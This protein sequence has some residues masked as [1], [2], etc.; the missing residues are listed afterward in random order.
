[1]DSF[2]DKKYQTPTWLNKKLS[3]RSMLKSAA[4]ATAI[5]AAPAFAL[6]K[7]NN[8]LA[9]QSALN[10][11]KWQ[12]LNAVFDHLFPASDSGPSAKDIQAT[13]YLYQLV[14]EQPTSQDEID[15]IYRGIGWLNGYTQS[16]QQLNFINLNTEQKEQTL[17]A[18]SRSEAGQNW[19]NMM[20]LN[21][22]EAMLSPPAYG[23]NPD[24]VGWKW[25][26][27][28]AGFPLPK[29]GNRYFE[30]PPRSQVNKKS[31]QVIK[32]TDL[33]ANHP[34]KVVKGGTKA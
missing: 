6:N 34:I 20:I 12:T 17:K 31:A 21:L 9:Y 18:I 15:F 25:L 23:G 10:N 4:G 13:Y 7:S 1:M 33:L 26:S 22:Y 8:E 27:H 5:A 28:Q 3:R 14:H 30:L 2:F 11:L 19:L 16:K 24:G 29:P 32:S